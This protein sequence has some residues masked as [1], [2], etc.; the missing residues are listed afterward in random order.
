MIFHVYIIYSVALDSFYIGFTE[1][2]SERIVQHNQGFYQGAY[3]KMANDWELFHYI[4]C[5]SK[6]QAILI[7]RHIKKMRSRKYYHS[8]RDYPE[9]SLKLLAHYL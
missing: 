6:K 7:E 1:S 9:I 5:E 3:T 8:L 4:E 2:L